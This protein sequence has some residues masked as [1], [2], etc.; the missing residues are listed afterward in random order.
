VRKTAIHT[1]DS[2]SPIVRGWL[3]GGIVSI[4]H[5]PSFLWT[6]PSASAEPQARPQPPALT[7]TTS[8]SK[9]DRRGA[10]RARRIV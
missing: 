8:N 1:F 10:Q 6:R 5:H 9:R 4:R 2:I 7:I 3:Y